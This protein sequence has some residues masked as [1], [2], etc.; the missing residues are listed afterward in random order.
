MEANEAASVI[1]GDA[2]GF[3]SSQ[4]NG[5]GAMDGEALPASDLSSLGWL[6][7]DGVTGSFMAGNL[8][9]SLEGI[10]LGKSVG[11]WL[12]PRVGPALGVDDG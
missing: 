2:V 4:A 6:A 11:S 1:D 5:T 8:V 9:G 3:A 12:G 7:G 10:E